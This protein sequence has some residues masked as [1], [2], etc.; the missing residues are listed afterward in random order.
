MTLYNIGDI[1]YNV[2]YD[3]VYDIVYDIAYI[4]IMNIPSL[5]DQTAPLH[6]HQ[7][8]LPVQLEQLL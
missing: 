6:R 2:V 4:F 5:G 3:V 7:D 1:V 8:A